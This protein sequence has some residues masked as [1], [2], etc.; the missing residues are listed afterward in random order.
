MT[1]LRLRR[2]AP[3]QSG[4]SS[5][6]EAIALVRALGVVVPHEA[7]EGPLQGR[8]TGEVVPTEGYTPVLL[9]NRALQSFDKAVGPGMARFGAR[10]P[11]V[12][13]AAGRIKRALELRPAIGED[14]PHRPA[15]ALVVR[16]DD[17]AQEC[18]GREG[19]VGRQQ[20]GQ[21]VRGGRIAR[22][23]LPD[24][25]D[26]FEVADVEGIQAHELARLRRRDVPRAAVASTPQ[27]LPGAFGQQPGGPRR[28]L[29][30]HGQPGAPRGQAD[31]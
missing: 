26:A 10:V 23:D 8:A 7:V 2:D 16:D 24:F 9:E 19:I 30:E 21:P 12:E 25:A 6:P 5:T 17:L 31:P 11:D 3:D 14:A 29:L 4:R 20:A 28:L 18:G 13:L 15:R 1:L 22:R 27:A